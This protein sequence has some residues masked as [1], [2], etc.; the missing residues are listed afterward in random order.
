MDNYKK[1]NRLKGHQQRIVFIKYFINPYNEKEYL[2]SGDREEKVIVWE[3][4]NEKEYKIVCF[5]NTLYGRLLMQQSIY[6]CI[7]Y[8]TQNKNYVY[9]TTVTSNY[10]R[11]YELENGALV[12]NVSITYYYYTFYLLKYKDFII[13]C[14]RNNVIIYQPFT[15][16]IYANIESSETKGDN[17]SACI[18]YNKN[19]IDYLY[20]S[21]SNG[22]VIG[23]DLVNKKIISIYNLN[24]DLYHIIFWDSENLIVT[25][26]N[27]EYLEIIN[28]ENKKA[29]NT[30]KCDS[31]LMCVKKILLNQNEEMLIT[32][33]EN[34][35]NIYLLNSSNTPS[36]PFSSKNS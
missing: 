5:I 25:E 26:Y 33:G 24:K 23:Y 19:N 32:S 16:E 15:E 35:K 2:I 20:I 9:T 12:K 8:S 11:L 3:I 30:I 21:N 7:L 34:T 4:I 10:S 13:D 6:N 17:R 28:I 22:N 31:T 1:I 29:R 18:I 14:C 27:T 36:T